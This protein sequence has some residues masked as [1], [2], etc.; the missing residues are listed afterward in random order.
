MNKEY[1]YIIIDDNQIDIFIAS[2]M[3]ESALPESAIVSFLNATDAL[4]M[5]Q[6]TAQENKISIVFVDINM[7]IMDGFQFMEKF[8]KLPANIQQY[9]IPCFLTSS[10]NESDIAIAKTF[11][12]IK[13]YINKPLT[14]SNIQSLLATL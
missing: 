10:I 13:L 9:Y 5:I 3:I 7:P 4:E 12:T 1:N 14:Q 8:E 6:N 11:K 2:K